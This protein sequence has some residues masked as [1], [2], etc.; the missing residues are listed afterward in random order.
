MKLYMLKTGNGNFYVLANHPTEAE[1]ILTKSLDEANYGYK[2]NRVA[3]E[4][5]II[6]T[7]A[8]DKRFLTGHFL[9]TK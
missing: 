8:N 5:H 4:I 1:E 7:E 6:A 2:H 9:I 3:T